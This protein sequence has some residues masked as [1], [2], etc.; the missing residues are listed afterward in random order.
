MI[1]IVEAQDGVDL[2]L[3]D[4]QTT[5]AANILSVQLGSLEYAKDLGIDLSFFLSEAFRFQDESFKA[6]LIQVLADRGINISNLIDTVENLFR[7]Y[8]L[9]IS[10]DETNTGLIAR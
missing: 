6:Y 3:F 7:Q 10:P 9:N 5:R 4:T 1:D 2:R 8:T